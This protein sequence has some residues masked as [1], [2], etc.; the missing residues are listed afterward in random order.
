MKKFYFLFSIFF[1]LN[2]CRQVSE[3]SDNAT[4]VGVWQPT[5]IRASGTYNG[6][7][8][9]Q[10]E[11]TNACQLQSRVTYN[12]DFS[13]HENAYDDASGNCELTKNRDYNYVYDKTTKTLT[14]NYTLGGSNS[15]QVI[16]LT[17]ITLIVRTQK[18]VNGVLADLEITNVRVK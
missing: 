12:T 7:P 10:N 13:G 1:I 17:S 3:S 9:V 11:D 8:F 5:H 2:S 18:I 15:V 16:E 14:H 4:L 6:I